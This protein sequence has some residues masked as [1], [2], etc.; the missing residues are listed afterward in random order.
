M[1]TLTLRFN[2]SGASKNNDANLEN[3]IAES[4]NENL[5]SKNNDI[6]IENKTQKMQTGNL[7]RR[8]NQTHPKKNIIEPNNPIVT[9]APIAPNAE[10]SQ[11]ENKAPSIE[12]QSIAEEDEESLKT[13]N[14][15][16]KT[17]NLQDLKNHPVEYLAKFAIS[18][19]LESVSEYGRQDIIY[20]ILKNFSDQNPENV[21][22]GEGVLEDGTRCSI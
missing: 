3:N 21:I 5:I 19:G 18:M 7:L 17:L 1:S 6:A 20:H 16:A 8:S 2:A 4:G 11:I 9:T 10:N 13:Q 22:V 14:A 12:S 15:G